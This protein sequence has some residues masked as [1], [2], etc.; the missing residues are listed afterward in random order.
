M[1]GNC[2]ICL[3]AYN[4]PASTPC[5]HVYCRKCLAGHVNSSSGMDEITA[6]CPTC[7]ST[8]YTVMPDLTYLPEKYHQYIIPAV[9]RVYIDNSS[10]SS[11]QR[12]L[13][14]AEVRVAKLEN[15]QEILLKQCEA[16]MAASQKK[17]DGLS[18]R[19]DAAEAL[20]DEYEKNASQVREEVTYWKSKYSKMKQRLD[21]STNNV[22]NTILHSKR[23][24]LG[25][26]TW[27]SE[28]TF[29]DD[30]MA[31]RQIKP[32]PRRATG[33]SSPQSKPVTAER[34]KRPRVSLPSLPQ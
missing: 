4:E 17:V 11:L 15:E 29:L 9:R 19:V 31:M 26:V 6:S 3:S 12:K 23:K 7:R 16:H 28:G 8:F 21:A 32:I 20:Q 22:D 5:G 27:H 13:A 1:S 10:A 14:R 18:T 2:S 24:S 33:A 25:N 34:P 30:S